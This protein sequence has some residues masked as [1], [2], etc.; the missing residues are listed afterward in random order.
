MSLH[1]QIMSIPCGIGNLTDSRR[2]G[3]TEKGHQ[4][5]RHAAA[6]L[7]LKYD[8]FVKTIRDIDESGD[9][10]QMLEDALNRLDG[11]QP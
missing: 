11:E 3:D 7:A 1:D 8:A 10:G 2:I 4:Q 9:C 5:A 6:E